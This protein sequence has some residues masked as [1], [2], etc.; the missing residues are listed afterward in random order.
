MWLI[1]VDFLLFEQN[2]DIK[3]KWPND[4][5]ANGDVKIGGLVVTSMIDADMAICN[6][7][8]GLNLSNSTPTT[9]VNDLINAYNMKYSTKLP[10]LTFEKTLAI[11]FNEIEELLNKIQNNKDLEHLYQEYYKHWLHRWVSII[12]YE[13]IIKTLLFIPS[14][15]TVTVRP[16]SGPEKTALITGIDEYGFLQIQVDG[17]KKT[18]SV[19]PDGNSFDMLR[20]LIIPK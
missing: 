5:Y 19:Q 17:S 1:T 18:E 10:L 3:L 8:L 4:I 15:S 7:G 13:A 11:I 6:V 9:C 20:G 2:L 14:G 16:P 12:D